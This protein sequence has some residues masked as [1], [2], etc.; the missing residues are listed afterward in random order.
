MSSREGFKV[1]TS[2]RTNKSELGKILINRLNFHTSLIFFILLAI[3]TIL[4]AVSMEKVLQF[5]ID[6]Y[7]YFGVV[8]LAFPVISG[9]VYYMAPRRT[10]SELTTF[11]NAFETALIVTLNLILLIL[12]YIVIIDL[13]FS[14]YQA[15]T[16]HLFLPLLVALNIPVYI[17]IRYSLLEKQMYF[18]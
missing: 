4:V 8:C 14:S 12:V 18:S 11:K 16:R 2:D 9:M 17:I 15:I 13:D 5:G 3:E 6:P 10:V 7:I 1:N